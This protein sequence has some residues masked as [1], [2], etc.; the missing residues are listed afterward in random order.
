MCDARQLV[1]RPTHARFPA[2][3]QSQMVGINVMNAIHD[4]IDD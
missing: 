3:I 1:I 2:F 4:D